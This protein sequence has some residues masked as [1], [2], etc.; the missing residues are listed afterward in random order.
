MKEVFSRV[1]VSTNEG[2]FTV[3]IKEERDPVQ[4]IWLEQHL[5][6]KSYRSIPVSNSGGNKVG[7]S[8]SFHFESGL[9]NSSVL[10]Q[11]L[12]QTLSSEDIQRSG[13]GV[14]SRTPKVRHV[15]LH[16]GNAALILETKKGGSCFGYSDGVDS[17]SSSDR[18]IVRKAGTNSYRGENSKTSGGNRLDELVGILSNELSSKTPFKRSTSSA[19]GSVGLVLSSPKEGVKSPSL[20]VWVDLTNQDLG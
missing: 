18:L 14:L 4:P 8:D 7:G 12:S 1:K 13:N 19:V 2:P 15:P 5:V 6:L 17:S 11:D 3:K 20:N 10:P 9:A 16:V